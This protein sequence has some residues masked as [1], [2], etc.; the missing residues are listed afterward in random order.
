MKSVAILNIETYCGSRTS[1]N[2]LRKLS[3]YVLY[4]FSVSPLNLDR[5]VYSDT[6]E[7]KIQIHSVSS[8]SLY[9][10]A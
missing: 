6:W 8:Y 1:S 2:F 10:N 9:S 5:M 3:L 7:S 4:S